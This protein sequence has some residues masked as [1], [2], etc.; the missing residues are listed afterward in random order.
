[1]I[2]FPTPVPRSQHAQRFDAELLSQTECVFRK[3]CHVGVVLNCNRHAQALF[4]F[5]K[6]VKSV[7]SRK[8]GRMMKTSSGEFERSRRS[9]S[10]AGE[11]AAFRVLVEQLEYG[12]THVIDDRLRA[13]LKTCGQRDRVQYANIGRVRRNPQICSAK[14]DANRQYVQFFQGHLRSP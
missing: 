14:I 4:H 8:I 11:F 9:H 3:H 1:M 12:A 13:R 6:Q 5:G 2:P 7:P 10:N